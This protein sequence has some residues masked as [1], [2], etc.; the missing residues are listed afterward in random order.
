VNGAASTQRVALVTGATR[1]I[2]RAVC[3]ALL[4]AGRRVVATGRDSAQL[5]ELERRHSDQLLAVH[6]DLAQPGA[7][8]Q[9]LARVAGLVGPLDELVLSAGMVRYAAAGEVGE[10]ELR[11][12]HEL[13]FVVP[14]LITQRVGRAMQQRG[15]GS[16]VHVASTLGL[17]PAYAASKA[18]LISATR[19]FALELAPQVRVNAVAPGVVDTAMVRVLRGSAPEGEAERGAALEAQLEGLR[20]LHPLGRLGTPEEV[21]E[22]VLYLLDARW[23]T[24]SV[25]TVDGGLTA[26]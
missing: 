20:A 23:V 17:R 26:G 13:N 10:A 3:G 25:L 18:A 5:M 16:I 2:G 6:C 19:S 11:A 12:Q 22:A 9:L 8:S 14:F 4:S 15:A 21:A 7:W 1:G 24:G